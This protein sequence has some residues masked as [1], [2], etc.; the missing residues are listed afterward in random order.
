MSRAVDAAEVVRYAGPTGEQLDHPGGHLRRQVSRGR[1]G[2]E[3]AGNSSPLNHEDSR[4]GPNWLD[5]LVTVRDLLW[6]AQ[7][8]G[9]I[10][11]NE[12]YLSCRAS[13][14]LGHRRRTQLTTPFRTP[15]ASPVPRNVCAHTPLG[16]GEKSSAI[17]S[18]RNAICAASPSHCSG[19]I[20]DQE[21][22]KINVSAHK[23]PLSS[24]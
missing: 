15:R 6:T 9:L 2:G 3:R 7:C 13:G 22:L 16:E 12:S 8:F 18:P 14:D 23:E 19:D 20:G 24:H 11:R 1:S 5:Q 4:T 10:G 17:L 21:Y